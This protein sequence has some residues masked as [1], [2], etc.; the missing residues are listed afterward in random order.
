MDFLFNVDYCLSELHDTRTSDCLD[1]STM[2]HR[3]GIASLETGCWGQMI[4]KIPETGPRQWS[5]LTSC[6]GRSASK[7]W[8]SSML[9]KHINLF[10]NLI[11]WFNSSEYMM[12]WTVAHTFPSQQLPRKPMPC[13]NVY[14]SQSAE[15]CIGRGRTSCSFCQMLLFNRIFNLCCGL[16]ERVLQRLQQPWICLTGSLHKQVPL[17]RTEHSVLEG[18]CDIRLS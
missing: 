15:H 18:I 6:R 17:T 13:H 12:M 2:V 10:F 14:I 3:L 5:T 4:R 9:D 11:S 7:G 1:L 8:I 16:S